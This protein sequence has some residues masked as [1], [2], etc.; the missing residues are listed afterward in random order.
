M[1]KLKGL[2][3]KDTKLDATERELKKSRRRGDK[4]HRSH[5]RHEARHDESNYRDN[6]RDSTHEAIEED[7]EI[8]L[9]P[10]SAKI[11]MDELRAKIEEARFREKMLDAM[12]EDGRLDELEASYNAY[13]PP[14]WRDGPDQPVN[15]SW[16]EEEEYAEWV[17][18]G[19]WRK[20]HREE[21]E[22]QERKAREKKAREEREREIRKETRRMEK[23]EDERR[24]KRRAEKAERRLVD[25]WRDY[26]ER[27]A[28]LLAVRSDADDKPLTS[29]T[30]ASL[31]WPTYP[32]PAD[33][34]ALTKEA[35]AAFLLSSL[36]S[37]DMTRKVRI[38]EALRVYHPDRFMGRWM[39]SVIEGDRK[40]VEE[41][42][43]RVV[44]ALTALAEEQ[45]E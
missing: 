11:D 27:W 9:T 33:P 10:S 29:L 4:K 35:V 42:V 32:V 30:F 22:A 25:A 28:T 17:R 3:L 24:R 34:D 2:K 15:P 40:I 20:T 6:Y 13:V 21:V 36:H 41:A 37:P 39:G 5:H 26:Q 12:A 43:G 31:P 18:Q 23:E 1:P 38:R 14:R 44:R 45:T 7:D 16:M 19:M 8:L